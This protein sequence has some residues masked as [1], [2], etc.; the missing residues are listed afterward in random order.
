[1]ILDNGVIRT[2]D[3]S[4]PVAR[5]R[6]R[7]RPDRRRGR[8]ARD[9]ARLARGRR[10]R[11]PVRA[12]R[13]H[14]LARA[15]PDVGGRAVRGAARGHADG[16]RGGRARARGARRAGR[17]TGGCAA[18]AGGAATGR[19]RSSRRRSCWT[20]SQPTS[21]SRS[22][23]A[24]RTRSGSTRRRSRANGDLQVPG[25]C[26]RAR[27]ARRA[28]RVLREESCWHFRD[29]YVEVSD[30]EYV[31]AMRTGVK[32]A[33]R[34]A[35]SPC[36][37]RTAGS[38]RFASGSG[39]PR[40]R[41]D[42]PRLAVAP[43]REGRRARVG[44]RPLRARRRVPAARLPEGVHGRD[45]RLADRPA[46]RR[47]R[48]ADHLARGARG[49][50]SARRTRAGFPVAVHAIGDLANREALDAFEATQDAWRPL[51][52]R[53]RIEHAQLLARR[54]RRAVRAARVAASVQFTHATSDRDLAERFWGD[55]AARAYRF[56]EL[57]DTGAL[58]RTAPTRPS[59]SSTRGS[60]SLPASAARGTSGPRGTRAR[61]HAR[62]GAAGDVRETGWLSGDERRR[63]KLL[64]G[65]LADLVVL[66]RD[67]YSIDPDE[68]PTCTSSR[69]WSAGDGCNPRPG[70]EAAPPGST[71]AEQRHHPSPL[72]LPPDRSGAR[73]ARPA[74]P[75]RRSGSA[76]S[77]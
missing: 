50:R 22:W 49:D 36:T 73:S 30:D 57:L 67:P 31:A 64:P 2:L 7:R 38:A 34:V 8:H 18:A 20:G 45:A 44:R 54:G 63:G 1:M 51:G 46:P 66:D 42:A 74:T 65:F 5:A 37:T 14:G 32:L 52:L 35:S 12:A 24:T 47:L 68:L 77:S 21:R 6:D 29:R 56:R 19:R 9:V 28:D 26:R 10:P 61:S 62:R 4:L 69:R 60:A 15:L 59:R 13:L 55:D 40:R 3:R 16:R 25:R 72:M 27:R 23:R 43:A 11:R 71:P 58:S 48:R 76:V 53:P 17:A 33:A 75:H 70:T 41:A 39:S